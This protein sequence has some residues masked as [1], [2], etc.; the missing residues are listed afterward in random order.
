MSVAL[1]YMR[2]ARCAGPLAARIAGA[3]FGGYALGALASVAALALPVS[4]PQGVITGMLASFIFY[5]GAVIWVFLARSA[6]RAWAGL[7][8]VALPLALAAWWA[9]SSVAS[10]TSAVSYVAAG[11]A[12]K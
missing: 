9:S 8:L 7:L 10:A 2:R 5:A 6:R 4:A 3:I 12:H 11:G 1:D